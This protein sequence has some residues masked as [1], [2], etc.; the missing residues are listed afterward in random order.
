MEQVSNNWVYIE[1]LYSEGSYEVRVR[2]VVMVQSIPLP[3]KFENG[4]WSEWKESEGAHV[5]AGKYL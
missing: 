5:T 3:T 4:P 1:G 2:C